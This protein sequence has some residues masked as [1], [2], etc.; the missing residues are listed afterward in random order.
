M[1]KAFDQTVRDL[2]RGV[3]KKVLKV[4]RVEQKI[5]DATSNEPWGPHGTLLAD[6]AQATRNYHEYQMIMSIIWK[7]INDTGKNWRHVYKALTV[8][9]YLVAHG[10]E[11]VI[12]D[13]REH[14]YQIGTLSDFQYIDSS[15][16][17]QGQNVRRKSQ[18]LVALV[19]N[20]ERIQEVRQKAA[21]NKEKYRSSISGNRPGSY[22]G[23]GG[24]RDRYDDDRYGDRYSDQN[25]Y[26]REREYEDRNGDRYGR[27]SEEGYEG[28]YSNY[29][30]GE[31]RG[32]RGGGSDGGYGRNGRSSFDGRYDDDDRHSSRSGGGS[33]ADD[34]SHDDRGIQRKFSEPNIA[35][36]V[37]PSYEDAT[38]DSPVPSHEE[39]NEANRSVPPAGA[40]SPSVALPRSDSTIEP[41]PVQ[42]PA[43]VPPQEPAQTDETPDG[44]D[45]FDPRNA[46]VATPAQA[47]PAPAPAAPVA[48]NLEMDFF[49]SDPVGPLALVTM[50][51]TA[52]TEEQHTVSS[53]GLGFEDNGFLGMPNEVSSGFGQGGDNP[54]GDVAFKAIPDST[55]NTAAPIPQQPNTNFAS[56][57][58]EPKMES[59]P[60]FNFG[61][62]LGDLSFTQPPNGSASQD[63]SFAGSTPFNQDN[64]FASQTGPTPFSANQFA[65]AGGVVQQTN[66]FQQTQAP[67][68]PYFVTPAQQSYPVPQQVNNQAF[69]PPVPFQPSQPTPFN[70]TPF[71]STQLQIAPTPFNQTQFHPSQQFQAT[72]PQTVPSFNQTP[73]QQTQPQ[74]AVPTTFNQPQTAGNLGL[75]SQPSNQ[76]SLF[77]METAAPPA[78]KPPTQPAKKFETKSSVWTDT[79]NRGLVNL[80]ISGSSVNPH[81]D[82]GIDFESMNRKEKREEK[83]SVSTPAVS[84]TMMGKAMGSGTGRANTMAPPRNPMAGTGYGMGMNMG[85][86]NMGMNQQ[87]GMGM[88]NGAGMNM[89]YGGIGMGMNNMG[90]GQQM[91]MRPPMGGMPPG[92][93]GAPGIGYNPMGGN[94]GYGAQQPYGGYR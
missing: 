91:G 80:N 38:R 85:G 10:S 92:G 43:V 51:S 65:P 26:G 57:F 60:S 48:N 39:R 90:A 58:Q 50:N 76:S 40:E 2:K 47:A 69:A 11:R 3:N 19:N 13:I 46:F 41:P 67:N 82:L 7:R 53:N 74:S 79:L 94:G 86:M 34:A 27:E 88:G 8:L 45:E 29:G 78:V 5:L 72:Q 54:F 73:F 17:D 28:R 12:D 33:R 31:Y 63:N 84:T 56:S 59:A 22:P 16:R 25:G 77:S 23:S 6:I 68:N 66:Q 87:M 81:A 32:G 35:S 52:S 30:D 15:G 70:Q 93:P 44:F 42:Q 89:G 75:L 62:S 21:A 83:K 14:S 55:T 37:P 18:S 24:E 20:K 64:S 49:G 4:P 9:D 71:Q 36:A 1:K 61:D